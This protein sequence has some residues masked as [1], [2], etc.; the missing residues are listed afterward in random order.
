MRG[1]KA[2]ALLGATLLLVGCGEDTP[3]ESGGAA[4]D[5]QQSTDTATSSAPALDE[6]LIAAL[7]GRISPT[8]MK[9]DMDKL[10]SDE[11]GGRLPGSHGSQLSREHIREKIAG[12]NKTWQKA[13]DAG[14]EKGIAD[15][16]AQVATAVVFLVYELAAKHPGDIP[17]PF[18]PE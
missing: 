1:R 17:P 9:K 6:K 10:A 8:R 4:V 14:S 7:H 16:N 18:P 12:F 11:M 13:I 5:T 15:W 2:M 3:K